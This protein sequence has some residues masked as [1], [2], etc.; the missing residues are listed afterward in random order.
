MLSNKSY[1]IINK[2]QRWL[3]ALGVFYLAIAEIW[4]LPFANEV[5]NTI[6]AIGTLVATFLEIMTSKWNKENSISITNY[7]ELAEELGEDITED[8]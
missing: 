3:V 1:D 6:V 8:K 7:K 4:H 2:A 5:N